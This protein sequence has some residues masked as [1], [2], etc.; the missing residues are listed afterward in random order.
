MGGNLT[1]V[2]RQFI[3]LIILLSSSLL[4]GV[5]PH[6]FESPY[7]LTRGGTGISIAS[8]RD[9]IFHNPAG[10]AY[11]RGVYRNIT[12]ASPSIVAS[13]GANALYNE[14]GLKEKDAILTT[15]KEKGKP[16]YISAQ[17]FSGFILRRVAIGAMQKRSCMGIM[18]KDPND[19]AIDLIDAHCLEDMVGTFTLAHRLF[20]KNIYIGATLKYIDRKYFSLKTLASEAERLKEASQS[21]S[22]G[23]GLGHDI[24][25]MYKNPKSAYS[26][27]VTM[28]NNGGLKISSPSLSEADEELLSNK[29]T[30]NV[31]MGIETGTRMS[32]FRFLIDYLDTS[33]SYTENPYKKFHFGGEL[34]VRDAVGFTFGLNQGYL[35]GGFYIDARVFRLDIGSYAEEV[36]E[37]IGMKPDQ[38]IVFEISVR[39]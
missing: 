28:K 39:M 3:A 36:G 8:D 27:G 1:T 6:D 5:G 10:V 16:Q 30:L 18:T 9:A 12:I 34:T 31:G 4:K 17:N 21:I 37:Y 22:R 20:S 14:I 13:A 23:T 24:G 26:F 15:I 2:Q 19:G 25:I 29:P 35:T 11:G 33:S 38:R 7:F 32:K